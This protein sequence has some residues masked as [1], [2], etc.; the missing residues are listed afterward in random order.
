MGRVNGMDV[1][2]SLLKLNAHTNVVYLTAY[3]EYAFDAWETGASGFLLKPL[4][5]EAVRAQ[6][7]RLRWPVRGLGV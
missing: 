1:C 2:R 5:A 4:D 7:A 6:L 3:R